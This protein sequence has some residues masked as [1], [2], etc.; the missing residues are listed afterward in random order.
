MSSVRW[1]K[2]FRDAWLHRGRTVLV[3]VAIAAGLAGGGIV[4]NAWAL[5]RVVTH[6]GF[7]AS[8][9]AAATLRLDS[10]DATVLARAK[11][12]PGVA[13][14]Q[15]RRTT[16]A[17]VL[18]G[19][20]WVPAL[21][22]THDDFE[23]IRIGIVQPSGP[24]WPPARG[25]LVIERS[26]LEFSGIAVGD[27]VQLAVGDRPALPVAVE[28]VARD[29]GLAPGWMEHL[30]YGF[31]SRET[32]AE[33]GVSTAL[34]ELQLVV[35]DQ[36]LGQ[37]G[38]REIAYAV[39][40][41]VEE[42]GRRVHAVDV[43]VP[44]EHVHAA[45]MNSL[46][47]TQ[48]AFALMALV[49]S[50]FLVFNLMAAMLAGQSREIGIMKAIGADRGQVARMYLAVAA[51]IGV[52]AVGLSFPVALVIG[53]EYATLKAELLNFDVTGYR[54]PAWV[55][56]LQVLVGVLVPVLAALIPVQAASGAPVGVALRDVG[57]SGARAPGRLLLSV[58]GLARPFLLSIR[59]AFR[60]RQRMAL[61]LV[62]LS[63][64]GSVFLASLNLRESVRGATRLLFEPQSHD[65][66][67]QLRSPAPM[68]SVERLVGGVA[69]VK[70]VEAWAAAR[71]SVPRGEGVDG[72]AF[73]IT[74]P[75][76][77]SRLLHYEVAR[78]R[79]LAAG[80]GR[81]LV[82][83]AALLRAEPSLQV[84]GQAT[85]TVGG[86]EGV[87]EV[88]GVVEGA[89]GAMAWAPREAVAALAT[90]GLATRLVVATDS[91]DDASAVMRIQSVR[92][93]LEDAG[94]GVASTQL[95]AEVRRVT[96][97]HLL[98]VVDFLAAMAWLMMLVGGLGLASTMGLAVLERTREIGVLRAIGASHGAIL[99]L[100]QLEG[101][102]IALL[103]W[104]VALP[105]SVPIS[106]ALGVAFG[107]IML[108]VPLMLLP[109]A[110]GVWLWLGVAVVGSVVASAWPARRATRVTTAAALAYE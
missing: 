95:I 66:S 72:N 75:A 5:V 90:N 34:D 76:P 88:V 40:R 57:M 27:E 92:S 61:T 50:A 64:G 58:Q 16:S 89:L 73:V 2:V 24:G 62:S 22:F 87:W 10:V 31:A 68:D 106:A 59:N 47:Y 15:A 3:V 23:A 6:E 65:F 38:V 52:L 91:G 29:V 77:N 30:V 100:V 45:Q 53:R 7:L 49:L 56:A 18:A 37:E 39:R 44:G 78:G 19:G 28:G 105:L 94:I 35:E 99:S 13:G 12:V 93:A 60:R 109:N 20:A 81:V 69:G 42:M 79:W 54:L 25:A 17:R 48:G 26:S 80:D 96:E 46:L 8:R 82:V 102:T 14:V 11:G 86:Q 108:P 83:S 110:Q 63:F 74:G 107:R 67:V 41:S 32:L 104:A 21:L 103:S 36:S 9:P 97:D 4:L 101:A 51:G 85:L 55:M 43:P 98:M 1:R 33:L 84:G 70:E 71:G